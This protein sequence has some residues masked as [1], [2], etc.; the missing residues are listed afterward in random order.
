MKI[1]ASAM[2][3]A[4]L[5]SPVACWAEYHSGPVAA[6]SAPPLELL[7]QTSQAFSQAAKKATPA[8]VS[9]RTVKLGSDDDTNSPPQWMMPPGHSASPGASPSGPQLG[10]GSGVVVRNDGLI[11]TNQHVVEHAKSIFV[12]FNDTDRFKAKLIGSDSRTDIAV[13]KLVKPPQNLS[14]IDF[15]NSDQVEVGDWALAIGSPFGLTHSVTSGIVSAKGRVHMGVYDIEDFIQTDAAINPGNSGGPLL[16]LEGQMI[17]LNAAI[18]SQT[19]GYMGIGFSISSNLARKV[20]DEI[21]AH[22]KVVRG[23]I[24]IVAQD[25]DGDLAE[26]F[27]IGAPQGALVSQVDPKGPAGI[28]GGVQNGDVIRKYSGQSVKNATDLKAAVNQTR[29]GDKVPIELMRAGKSR[30]VNLAIGEAP[31]LKSGK[32]DVEQAG[33]VADE[34]ED[35]SMGLAVHDIPAELETIVGV[36]PGAGALVTAVSPGGH[37][38]DA[39]VAPGDIILTV[40]Q[41]P[42]KGAQDV[43]RFVKGLKKKDLAVFYLQRGPERKIYV[44]IRA[45]G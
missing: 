39:G 18:F 45:A 4:C 29:V 32:S 40:N 25:M 26:Y 44:P 43:E 3:L 7:K 34:S 36:P 14:V 9:I 24:G 31:A 11:L 42:M 15:A 12:Y 33:S 6:L 35:H 41:K 30:V 38:F 5:A 20:S 21:I 19:G 28:Q 27:K 1:F 2:L 10:V 22:G 8:V 23:Y 16:N 17:G 37:A 13:L